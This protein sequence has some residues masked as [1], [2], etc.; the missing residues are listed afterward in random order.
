MCKQ[1]DSFPFH[2]LLAHYP[3]VRHSK[4]TLA[5][6]ICAA[7]SGLLVIM[8]KSAL[9]LTFCYEDGK[10]DRYYTQKQVSAPSQLPPLRTRREPGMTG[11]NRR[12]TATA[13]AEDQTEMQ[14]IILFML[15][16]SCC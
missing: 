6:N 13:A 16:H 4:M 7:L 12:R 9:R 14:I 3:F 10:M 11:E 2:H 8:L 15:P 5:L 1:P